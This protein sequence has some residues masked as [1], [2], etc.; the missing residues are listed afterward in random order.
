MAKANKYDENIA[1]V[2]AIVS[3]LEQA[4]AISMDEYKKLAAEA[5]GL[6]KECKAEITAL[7]NELNA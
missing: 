5:A 2:E 1:R 7:E 4:E 6:L 3:R